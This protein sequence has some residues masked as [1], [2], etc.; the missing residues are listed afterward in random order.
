MPI[1]TKHTSHHLNRMGADNRVTGTEVKTLSSSVI[2]DLA[3]AE[4][5]A[6]T[7]KQLVKNLETFSTQLDA[8]ADGTGSGPKPTSPAVSMNINDLASELSDVV[9]ELE[10]FGVAGLLLAG[11][12]VALSDGRITVNEMTEIDHLAASVVES[13]SDKSGA[14]VALRKILSILEGQRLS[15]DDGALSDFMSRTAEKGYHKMDV[16]LARTIAQHIDTGGTLNIDKNGIFAKEVGRL[17]AWTMDMVL[18]AMIEME[19]RP[20]RSEG[21]MG[22]AKGKMDAQAEAHGRA[23]LAFVQADSDIS[24]DIFNGMFPMI[25]GKPFPDSDAQSVFLTAMRSKDTYALIDTVNQMGERIKWMENKGGTVFSN[26]AKAT[27]ASLQMVKTELEARQVAA[28]NGGPAV[29]DTP[30]VDRVGGFVLPQDTKD[31]LNDE[32]RELLRMVSMIRAER[33]GGANLPDPHWAELYMESFDRLFM[34][35]ESLVIDTDGNL[36]KDKAE[37]AEEILDVAL[38]LESLAALP[39]SETLVALLRDTVK[40]HAGG[41]DDFDNDAVLR[42]ATEKIP[43]FQDS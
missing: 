6:A 34:K 27:D 28:P 24:P 20:Y 41:N 32:L 26:L 22:P 3:S 19:L 43:G 31:E 14:A 21:L 23:L 38:M 15:D 5:G 1:N 42:M 13:A 2:R 16:G 11:L 30:I 12:G 17:D 10:Q 39:G 4:N 9:Y 29:R 36:K 37:T 25:T 7:L 8:V 33:A 35:G 40:H 18:P